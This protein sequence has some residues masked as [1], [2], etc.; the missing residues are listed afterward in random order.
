MSSKLSWLN[1]LALLLLIIVGASGYI[2]IFRERV[3]PFQS[4][5]TLL[6]SAN[7]SGTQNLYR[8]DGEPCG[9]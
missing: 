9:R 5:W 2:S 3:P 8:F 7:L 6:L 4:E 1:R